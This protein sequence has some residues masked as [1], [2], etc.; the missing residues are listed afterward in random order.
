MN[1]IRKMKQEKWKCWDQNTSPINPCHMKE[2]YSKLKITE[3]ATGGVLSKKV[4]LRISQISQGN[5]YVGGS[6]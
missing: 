4:F 5:T 2:R 1:R 3:A 6:F